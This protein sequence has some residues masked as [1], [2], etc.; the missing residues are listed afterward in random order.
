MSTVMFQLASNIPIESVNQKDITFFYQS[1]MKNKGY[2][3]LYRKAP[4]GSS[5]HGFKILIAPLIPPL[6]TE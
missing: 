4:Q 1:N 2:I 3:F 5:D 6:G